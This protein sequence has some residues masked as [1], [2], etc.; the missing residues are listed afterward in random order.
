MWNSI[1]LSKFAMRLKILMYLNGE[2]NA[3]LAEVLGC[4]AGRISLLRCC[5]TRPTDLEVQIL[6]EH[7]NVSEKF[8]MGDTTIALLSIDRGG[9]QAIVYREVV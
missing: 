3:A 1:L 2:D 9:N 7:Y 4:S 6:A 8:I 5:S